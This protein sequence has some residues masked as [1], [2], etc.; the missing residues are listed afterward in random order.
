MDWE[1]LAIVPVL[2][3]ALVAR[4]GSKLAFNFRDVADR[5]IVGLAWTLASNVGSRED[6]DLMEQV[7]K[8]QKPVK[9]HEDAVGQVEIG[10]GMF[11]DIFEM[12]D[13]IIGEVSDRT[14]VKRRQA[15]KGCGAML[16]KQS[17]QNLQDIAFASLDVPTSGDNHFIAGSPDFHIRL[18]TQEGVASDAFTSLYGFQQEGPRFLIGNGQKGGNGRQQVRHN[19]L[20]DWNQGGVPS[21]PRK[22]LVIGSDTHAITADA[23]G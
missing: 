22:F 3:N 13:G 1:L 6:I 9:E 12:A 10:A 11:A 7:I 14:G 8:H 4:A 19:G 20:H 17:F 5:T 21:Q 15:G 16:A 18:G 23:L 2:P